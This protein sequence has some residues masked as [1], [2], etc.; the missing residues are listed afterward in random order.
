MSS[1]I[2]LDESSK[3]CLQ[4]LFTLDTLKYEFPQGFIEDFAEDLEFP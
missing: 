2:N 1:H 3:K 4:L